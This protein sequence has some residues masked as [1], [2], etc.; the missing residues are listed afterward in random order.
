MRLVRED[1]KGVL[2]RSKAQTLWNTFLLD[3]VWNGRE[4]S[5]CGDGEGLADGRLF[6]QVG[7][8]VPLLKAL[9]GGW[10]W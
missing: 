10:R 2:R 4:R 9:S 1:V 7:H 5:V 3:S 6:Q 8:L